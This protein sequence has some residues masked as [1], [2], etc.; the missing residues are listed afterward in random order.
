MSKTGKNARS[1]KSYKGD[2][3]IA[4]KSGSSSFIE[5]LNGKGLKGFIAS[6]TGLLGRLS[7]NHTAKMKIMQAVSN[8]TK[9]IVND[10]DR[11]I[12]GKDFIRSEFKE[13]AQDPRYKHL[14]AS[15]LGS[16]MGG[17]AWIKKRDANGDATAL[18]KN[19]L[20]TFMNLVEEGVLTDK[21]IQTVMEKLGPKGTG[22]LQNPD[23]PFWKGLQKLSE[24]SRV[25]LAD[26]ILT[27]QTYQE[28]NARLQEIKTT[29]N[30]AISG[31]KPLAE[32]NSALFDCD[33][34]EKQYLLE[35]NGFQ[36]PQNI[37]TLEMC[38][39]KIKEI[40]TDFRGGARGV[41]D[42]VADSEALAKHLA[43]KTKQVLQN[44][45]KNTE[46]Q[47]ALTQCQELFAEA[48]GLEKE[49]FSLRSSIINGQHGYSLEKALDKKIADDKKLGK[50][51]I[52]TYTEWLA[53]ITERTKKKHDID[54]DIAKALSLELNDPQRLPEI[55]K[56][57]NKL[58]DYA[59]FF[60]KNAK[61]EEDIMANRDA[62]KLPKPP[63]NEVFSQGGT[64]DLL[65]F[66]INQCI[67]LLTEGIK[68]AI[69]VHVPEGKLEAFTKKLDI[70]QAQGSSGGLMRF[71]KNVAQNPR[72]YGLPEDFQIPD[73]LN[74]LVD[75]AEEF[76]KFA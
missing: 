63:M 11:E 9:D 17:A 31:D 8:M 66:G 19:A 30:N 23:S 6:K 15:A 45:P 50:A 2:Q 51:G 56:C 57:A 24:E 34:V 76:N 59:D 25:K 49:I 37:D 16:A 32:L 28:K 55:N 14:V 22:A 18:S 60:I 72:T 64:G 73:S 47:K 69:Q 74:Q 39:H 4:R 33:D 13:V 61:I 43:D 44:A 70:I 42:G 5:S 36:I 68:S 20:E 71:I 1:I 46:V 10:D 62:L 7:G 65:Q 29:L 58:I 38:D 21:D 35:R 67:K 53:K 12:A 3:S 75:I 40:T 26:I 41:R 48:Q 52:T 27:S 54:D